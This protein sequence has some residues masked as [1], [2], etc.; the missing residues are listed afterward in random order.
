[1]SIFVDVTAVCGQCGTKKEVALAASVNADRRPDLRAEIIEGVFQATDCPNCGSRMRLPA[2]LT[3]I[4][5]NRGQW[6]L[7]ET[8]A[9]V[10]RWA[11]VETEADRLYATAF[12]DKA[13]ALAREMG[14]GIKP[15]LV[16]G[17][18]AL[19]EKLLAQE[20]GLDDV[21]L[22]LTKIAIMRAVP[23]PPMGDLMEMR[24]SEATDAELA[25]W[26]HDGATEEAVSE[27]R[28]ER[29]VYDAIAGDPGPWEPLRRDVAAGLF[30][31]MKRIFI[32]DAKKA[33]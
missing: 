13:P 3:Y 8:G 9:D 24:L 2:H 15:R 17:W 18:P 23:L 1:M 25:F 29:A 20:A 4:D 14:K 21:T 11:E 7:V 33:A 22:E 31:D 16:F 6:I 12:G 10:V 32:G 19:R 30:T 28:V 26:W 5:I 27:V